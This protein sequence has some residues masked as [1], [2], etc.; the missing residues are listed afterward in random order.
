MDGELTVSAAPSGGARFRIA[1]AL[2][3]A[4]QDVAPVR[5][6]QLVS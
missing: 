2:A 4:P 1:I 6:T 5:Q 3:A